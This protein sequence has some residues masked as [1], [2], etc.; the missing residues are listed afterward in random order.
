MDPVLIVIGDAAET[1]DTLYPYYRLQEDGFT[2][3][4]AAPEKRKY[5]MVMHEVKPGWTITK[6]WE[7]YTLDADVTFAEIQPE[8]YLGIMF[9]GGRAP[10]YIRE[11]PDLLRI[12]RYFFDKQLPIASVCHGVEIPARADCVR[13]RR[14][15]TVAKCKFDLEVCGGI[16]VNEPCV[17]DGNLVSGRT[18]HDNGKYVGPWIQLLKQERERRRQSAS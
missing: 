3:V 16:Y 10:E 5:Q 17:I 11:D 18:Y 13:G 14:M 1:L 6:E 9:S 12:T 7:G 15:A 2:P 8:R 4:V